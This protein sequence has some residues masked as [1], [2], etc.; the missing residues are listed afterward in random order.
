[1]T[2]QRPTRR[3]P[4][5]ARKNYPNQ[6]NEQYRTFSSPTMNPFSALA[7]MANRSSI[8]KR[9]EARDS[10]HNGSA[11]GQPVHAPHQ[12]VDHSIGE[13]LSNLARRSTIHKTHEV[14]HQEMKHD[15]HAGE[16]HMSANAV[17][18]HKG[19]RETFVSMSSESSIYD[20]NSRRNE[21][22]RDV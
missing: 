19:L 13:T 18:H 20:R 11:A 5:N 1:M 8:Y 7:D 12:P 22:L 17:H 4:H 10:S 3:R 2:Q 9:H 16:R 14:H 15:P 6:R 21:H